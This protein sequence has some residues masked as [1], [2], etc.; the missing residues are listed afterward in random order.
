[1][2]LKRGARRVGGTH[3]GTLGKVQVIVLSVAADILAIRVVAAASGATR[4]LVEHEAE[5][6]HVGRRQRREALVLVASRG[7]FRRR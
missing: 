4:C 3:L 7:G 5:P 2:E 6:A 1:M